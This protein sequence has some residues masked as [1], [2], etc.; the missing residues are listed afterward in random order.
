MRAG[1]PECES[2]QRGGAYTGMT[3]DLNGRREVS[4]VL[5]KCQGKLEDMNC[6]CEINHALK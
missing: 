1:R 4:R 2:R 5:E 6:Q 3:E